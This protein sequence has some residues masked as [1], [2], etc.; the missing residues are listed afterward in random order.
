MINEGQWNNHGD[1]QET[2]VAK[3]PVVVKAIDEPVT[4]EANLELPKEWR[5]PRDLSLDNVIGQMDKWTKES[6][7]RSL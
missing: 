1:S 4:N 2:K 5:V 7:P 3:E 6:Q